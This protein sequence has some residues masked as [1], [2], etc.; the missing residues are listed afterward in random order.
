MKKIALALLVVV[1]AGSLFLYNKRRPHLTVIGFVNMADGLGRQAPELID[2]LQKEISIGFIPTHP[3][4]L[5]D[6]P[7][8]ALPIVS[9]KN[10]RIGKVVILTDCLWWPGHCPFKRLKTPA[11]EKQIRI[12]YSMFESTQIPPMWVAILNTYFDAV[13]VPDRYYVDVYR[14]SG[15]KLPIFELP[16]GVDFQPF[17]SAP[18][19][20]QPNTPFVFANLSTCTD[21]KNQ[22]ILVRAFAK[23]FGNDP[24]YRLLLNCRNSENDY[25]KLVRQEIETLGLK[26]VSFM[27]RSLPKQAYVELVR[28]IDCYVNV[29]KG[30]GFSIQPR[31]AMALGIPVICSDNTAQQTICRTGLIR[32]VAADLTEPALYP[33]NNRYYGNNFNCS[34]DDTADA[35]KD[36]SKNYDKYLQNATEAR[37][38]ASQYDYPQIIALYRTLVKPKKVILGAENQI[39]PDYLMT[40]SEELYQKYLNL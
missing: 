5:A 22:I 28:S 9:K 24:G 14:N 19:K 32:P 17:L 26:N 25:D 29:A 11:N 2:A 40:D 38:W 7:T 21:R 12:A 1:L 34:V 16:M 30:E 39:T 23:A 33:W 4:K 35:L 15:V 3:N 37:T 31:E 13:A 18:L 27:E 10:E 36:V 6:V 20:A 8:G